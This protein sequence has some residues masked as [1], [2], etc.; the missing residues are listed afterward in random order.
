[1]SVKPLA[2]FRNAIVTTAALGLIVLSAG[3]VAADTTPPSDGFY[4]QNGSRADLYA[5]DCVANGDDTTA[6]HNVDI[7][8]PPSLDAVK[9]YYEYPTYMRM[10]NTPRRQKAP[11]P[12]LAHV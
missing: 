3:P 9:L 2:R 6:V 4:S 1:M 5:S 12:R 7:V 10:A 8:T 11:W